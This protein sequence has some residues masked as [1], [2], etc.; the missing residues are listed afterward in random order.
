VDTLRHFMA[1][2]GG[3]TLGSLLGLFLG[4]LVLT[5]GFLAAVFL[6]L[7]LGVGFWLG[8]RLDEDQGLESLWRHFFPPR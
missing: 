7:C 3:K 8:K 5:R 4:W 2:H 1:R 6:V